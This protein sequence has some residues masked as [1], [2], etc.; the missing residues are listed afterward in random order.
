[1]IEDYDYIGIGGFVLECR[2]GECLGI[3]KE[4]SS[5]IRESSVFFDNCFRHGTIEASEGVIRKPDW[6]LGIARHLIEVLTKQQTTVSNLEIFQELM[7]AADQ[8][9]LDLRLCSMVN[10]T[11]PS[12]SV[13]SKAKFLDLVDEEKY[14]FTFRANMKS[15]EWLQLLEE[16]VLLYRS[17]TNYAVR[18]CRD[19]AP[20]REPEA[21]PRSAAARR[22]LDERISDFQ[23]HSHRAIEAVTKIESVISQAMRRNC[24]SM[25][26][27]VEEASVYFETTEPLSK[28]YHDLIDR[29]GG[30]EACIRTCADASESKNTEG[31]T[32]RGSFDVLLRAIQ[33]IL[34]SKEGKVDTTTPCSLRID[35]PTPDTLGRFIN[36]SQ[37]AKDYPN[38]LGMDAAMG[39]YFCR[40]SIRDIELMLSYLADF[41]TT[42]IVKKGFTVFEYSSEDTPF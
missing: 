36:A 12:L 28:E 1:M 42:S 14:C 33:P 15:H 35:Y 13:D 26:A 39:R 17:E 29:L 5:E 4:Q 40:K 34:K 3:T 6:S 24:V 20:S 19:E 27:P 9:C 30:G 18:L 32:I 37:E 2:D 22:N 31:Y 10:Y 8:A 21:S 23:V 16:D 41:S 38:T 11:D 25:P 7:G